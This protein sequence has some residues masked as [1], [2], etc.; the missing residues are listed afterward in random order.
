MLQSPELYDLGD[1]A[2]MYHQIKKIKQDHTT[3]AML[4]SYQVHTQLDLIV[5]PSLCLTRT[6]LG[7]NG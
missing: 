5:V 2:R 1:Y 6:M 7:R 4:A 3:G